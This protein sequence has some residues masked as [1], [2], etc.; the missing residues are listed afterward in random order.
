MT[1]LTTDL[2][3]ELRGLVTTGLEQ[4]YTSHSGFD[5]TATGNHYQSVALGAQATAGFRGDR[6][7]V[8]D[9][10]DF[11]GRKVLDLGSNLGEM[12]RSAR[13]R[14]ARL[15]DGIEYDPFFVELSQMITAYN[16]QTRVSF[17]QGDI[18]D[19]GLYEERYDVVMALS[20]FHYV[21]RVLDQLASITDVLLIETHKLHGNFDGGYLLPVQ[22][23]FP[24]MRVLGQ[25]D[26]GQLGDG[27]ETRLVVLFAKDRKLL[28]NALSAPHAWAEPPSAPA[29]AR[30]ERMVDP[31][32]SRTHAAFF[33]AWDYEGVDELLDAVGSIDIPVDALA[34]NG[35]LS[36]HGYSGWAYWFLY[37][38]GWLSY[39]QTGVVGPGNP[40][41]DYMTTH[42]VPDGA[43]AAVA[44]ALQDP[45][46]AEQMIRRRFADLDRM[47]GADGANVSSEIGPIRAI[48]GPIAPRNPLRLAD[49]ST[50]ETIPGRRMDGWHRMF[51]ARVLG[52]PRLRAEIVEESR[53]L[54]PLHGTVETFSIED[55][56]VSASGWCFHPTTPLDGIELR[57]GGETIAIGIPE[58]RPDVAGAHD[59]ISHAGSSGFHLEGRLLNW[60]DEPIRFE[61]LGIR[62]WLP[63][64]HL[65]MD[66]EP[67][68]TNAPTPPA[69]LLTKVYGYSNPTPLQMRTALA[70][71][72]LLDALSHYRLLDGFRDAVIWDAGCG[73]LAPLAARR[74][75]SAKISALVEDADS[76]AWLADTGT[77]Q[78]E[79]MEQGPPTALADG[80]A[81]LVLRDRPLAI[82]SDDQLVGWLGEL[83]RLLRPGGYAACITGWPE[84]ERVAMIAL[85][86]SWLDVVGAVTTAWAGG[87]VIVLRRP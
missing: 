84:P 54:R 29:P 68:L 82:L 6:S 70:G 14:G 1:E 25:T 51:G 21:S 83:R 61:L 4:P 64:G 2:G 86:S 16:G 72:A 78:T 7:A 63:V 37:L 42:Y 5:G 52:A 26:W 62:D 20:V 85:C 18:T 38:K 69:E 32:A 58:T 55:G 36:R 45:A 50:G 74:L 17:R 71:Q 59:D 27:S 39:R 3:A 65:R 57:C 47:A 56:V 33:Q 75:P 35:N 73:L 11:R 28:E 12:S 8:L 24:A 15:V 34:A 40:Y 19:P 48:V 41:F 44:R 23:R 30:Y 81:D 9:C 60:T 13:S 43:D 53:F 79:P 77:V 87:H 46:V 10:V 31:A 80:I 66:Y 67:A 76:R 22:E 49:S